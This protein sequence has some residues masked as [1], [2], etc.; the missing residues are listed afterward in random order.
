MGLGQGYNDGPGPGVQ[1]CPCTS[2]L[3]YHCSSYFKQIF[4][5][6]GCTRNRCVEDTSSVLLDVNFLK[7]ET[8]N[9]LSISMQAVTLSVEVQLYRSHRN[10]KNPIGVPFEQ[11]LILCIVV[12][13]ALLCFHFTKFEKT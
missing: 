3:G 12:V 8:P 10:T 11:S 1:C 5:L 9:F 6:K 7:C 4:D 13:I 2:E